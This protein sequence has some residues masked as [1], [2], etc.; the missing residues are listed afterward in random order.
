MLK[1]RKRRFDLEEILAEKKKSCDTLK[2]TCDFLSEKVE[3]PPQLFRFSQACI[4]STVFFVVLFSISCAHILMDL[5]GKLSKN[6]LK[7]VEDDLELLYR[8]DQLKMNS[9]DIMIPLHLNQV[10]KKDLSNS[11]T[12]STLSSIKDDRSFAAKKKNLLFS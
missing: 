3:T 5:Q 1:L 7:A 9:L 12:V 2:R 6:S 10:K 11:S 8:E 4:V